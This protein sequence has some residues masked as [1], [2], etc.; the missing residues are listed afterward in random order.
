MGN[1]ELRGPLS[2]FVFSI[3]LLLTDVF[4][5]LFFHPCFVLFAPIPSLKYPFRQLWVAKVLIFSSV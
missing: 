1:S 5:W 4:I 2:H 3:L